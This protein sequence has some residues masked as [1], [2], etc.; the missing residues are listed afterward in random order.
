MSLDLF[1]LVCTALLS[2]LIPAVYLTG[3]V[4]TAGG[5]QWAFGNRETELKVPD[6]TAR[7]IR[8]HNNL[9]ENLAPFAILVIAA[10]LAGKSGG[11]TAMGAAIFFWA[12]VAHLAIY[13]AGIIGLRT[14]VFFVGTAGEIMILVALFS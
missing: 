9:T 8:A 12:R 7:A 13:T 4:Q 14:L 3:R 11:L 1:W 10:H 6:W 2:T 5:T